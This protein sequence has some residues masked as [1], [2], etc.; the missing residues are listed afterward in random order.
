MKQLRSDNIYQLVLPW[1][2]SDTTIVLICLLRKD[3]SRLTRQTLSATNISRALLRLSSVTV[4]KFTHPPVLSALLLILYASRFLIP[5]FPLLLS[6]P[7]LSS[8]PSQ[9][10]TLPL[11]LRNK[12]SV[13]FLNHDHHHLS[14]NREGRW[15]TTDDAASSFFNFP[16]FSTGL[17]DLPNSRPVYSLML[18]A[19]WLLASCSVPFFSNKYA[20]NEIPNRAPWPLEIKNLLLSPVYA[21]TFQVTRFWEVRSVEART[22]YEQ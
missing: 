18:S 5:D 11:P 3:F 7:S 22:L 4:S 19:N 20:P 15:G 13:D 17:W 6:V 14:L 10:M 21:F 9:G 16:L 8:A 12:P 2:V 1:P